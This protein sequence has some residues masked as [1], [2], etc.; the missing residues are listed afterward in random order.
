MLAQESDASLVILITGAQ[1]HSSSLSCHFAEG[2]ILLGQKVN[3]IKLSLSSTL[4]VSS[5][6]ATGTYSVTT[7]ANSGYNFSNLLQPHCSIECFVILCYP[8]FHCHNSDSTL[9]AG[10]VTSSS[11]HQ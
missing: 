1:V 9:L 3:K 8:L 10:R 2:K 7:H 4:H 6:L 11:L 5:A